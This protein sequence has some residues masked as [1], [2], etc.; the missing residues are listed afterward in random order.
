MAEDAGR[1]ILGGEF[2]QQL[3]EGVL[4]GVGAGVGSFAVLV[5]PTL[6]DD[7]ETAVIVVAGMDTLDA[8]GQQGC[9]VTVAAHIVVV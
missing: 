5:E 1:G 8:L 2:L 9:H 4:L 3:I 7:A 6:I